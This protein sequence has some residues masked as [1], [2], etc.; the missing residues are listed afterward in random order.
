MKHGLNRQITK[1][2]FLNILGMLG[3]SFYILIDT[4][5]I[6]IALGSDGLAALNFAISIYSVLHG[7]GL[8]IGLGGAIMFKTY[9]TESTFSQNAYTNSVFLAFAIGCMLL[10]VGQVWTPLLSVLLGVPDLLM[11]YVN[12]YLKTI[13]S[14]SFVFLVNNVLL[15]FVRNDNGPKLAMSAM[16]L[17]SFSNILL[18]ALF[19]FGFNWGMFG[20]AFATSLSALLSVLLLTAH[21]LSKKRTFHFIPHLSLSI[22]KKIGSYGLFALIAELA[23]SVSLIVFNLILIRQVGSDGVAAYA[24]I[25]NLA[26]IVTSIFVGVSH[27]IQP[28]LS[29]SY[30]RF[31]TVALM[32]IIKKS[33]L[34]V[35][36]LFIL[37][38]FITN[39][40]VD[41]L[42]YGFNR[43]AN[44]AVA[45]IAKEGLIVYFTG[46]FF[47][48]F[49]IVF[50]TALSALKHPKKAMMLTLLRSSVLLIP[51]ALLLSQYF[52]YL[53]LWIAFIVS[54][55]LT[56]LVMIYFYG[57]VNLTTNFNNKL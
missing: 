30:A 42:V 2:V 46:Y 44:N 41:E 38:Y 55:G 5:F 48:G 40:F 31:D 21:L 10:I 17:S 51:F 57:R 12:V 24:I 18:D 20:A 26:L 4:L 32:Q 3:L 37:I 39:F 34:I 15:A 25:A 29:E 23:L 16:L 53:G 14:F 6:S 56:F 22:I 35:L 36:V 1:Y 11:S 45:H 52:D 7:L 9:S 19:I 43:D 49:N 27:G 54:E 47:A 33:I 13:L 28:L 50:S 8:M